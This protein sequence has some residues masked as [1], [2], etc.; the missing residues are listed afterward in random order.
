MKSSMLLVFLLLF[1]ISTTAHA[2]KRVK[3]RSL[4]GIW[5]L[6]IKIDKDADSAFGRIVQNSVEGFLDEIDIYMD[7]RK[8]NELVVT[9]N[10]FGEK[11][12]EYSEWYINDEGEL[13]IGDSEHFQSDDDTVWM[14]V[15]DRLESF[16][17]RN[18]KLV[19]DSENV[20]LHRV[21]S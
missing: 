10:A 19:N 21:R 13:H 9:V 12:V 11:E 4:R 3:E 2:Q 18:G 16:E 6:E 8:N 14:F 15:G 1:G 20:Y 17:N 7:F 5:K